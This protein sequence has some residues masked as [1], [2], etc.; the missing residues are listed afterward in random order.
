MKQPKKKK[1][2]KDKRGREYIK[3]AY[4]VRGKQK[5]RRIFVIDGIPAEEFYRRNATDIDHMIN[6]EYWLIS[7]EQE[8]MDSTVD[9]ERIDLLPDELPF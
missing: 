3:E 4:F 8:S 6:G 7:Y 9:S 2:Y 1:I 5:F